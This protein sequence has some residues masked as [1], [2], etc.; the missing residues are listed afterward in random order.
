VFV[1]IKKHLNFTSLRKKASEIFK[2][3]PDWRQT[4][5]ISIS[6][7]DAM[8]SGLACMYFQDPS[9]LQFQKRMEDEQHK[10]NLN[11]LFDVKSIPKETQMR[12]IIDQVA[13]D[14]FR[15]LFRDYYSRVQRGKHLEQFQIFPGFY[16]FPID[17]SH[18][19]GSKDI[20]CEQCLVKEHRDGSK[21]YSHQVLQGGIAHPD[22]SQVIPFMPEQ[23][24][25]TDGTTKQDC[26]T[27]RGVY[28][29]GVKVPAGKQNLMHP[30]S[31]FELTEVTT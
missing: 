26:G 5:K 14:Y 12:E 19:S 4:N 22:C 21:S 27:P 31:S 13:S 20:H 25:N 23:I 10:N 17:G 3:I 9:L 24:V 11:T 28:Q 16:Y 15:P 2:S 8:M 30:V 18:F 6:I 1:K 7:H 29:L